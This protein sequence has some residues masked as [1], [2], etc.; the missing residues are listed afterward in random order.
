M[1][2]DNSVGPSGTI[3]TTSVKN[4]SHDSHITLFVFLAR[5][6]GENVRQKIIDKHMVEN[7]LFTTCII[8]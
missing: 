6:L 8:Y 7:C 5:H 1:H 3:L 2:N 4:L